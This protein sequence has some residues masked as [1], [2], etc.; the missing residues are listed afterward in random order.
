[1]KFQRRYRL[2][3]SLNDGE[4][5]IIIQPPFTIQFT[6]KRSI[7]ASM[8]TLDIAIYNLS[9]ESRSRIFQDRY[10]IGSSQIRRDIKFEAGYDSLS[11]I[12]QGN[13]FEANSTRRGVDI[14]TNISA[15]SGG[16]DIPITK[17][18]R[19]EKEGRRFKD[20]LLGLMG[21]FQKNP[22]G[23]LQPGV[24]SNTFEAK[25]FQRPVVLEGNTFELLKK[26][27]NGRVFVDLDK[28]NCLQDN[29]T[30]TGFIQLLSADTGLLETPRRDQSFLSL[31]TLFEPR[32]VMGQEVNIY[33]T[34][35]PVYNGAYKIVGLTHEGI[36]S[37]AVNGPC[38]SMFN[39][40]SASNFG[41]TFANVSAS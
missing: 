11:T 36:I 29:E 34:V 35:Q 15:F 13:F 37:E 21:D 25:S 16:W 23:V 12:F 2:T 17:T 31:T 24:I 19:T 39:M 18:F 1:M 8:N 22:Q 10:L 3:L 30:V 26:Y 28:V 5:E 6:V 4:Q 32:I 33:S 41:G 7:T 20:V 14:L 38:R 27:T 40:I 9:P